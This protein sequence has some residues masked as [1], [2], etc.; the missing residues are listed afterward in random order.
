[1]ESENHHFN[2][3]HS[4]C[5]GKDHQGTLMPF[6]DR[7]LGQKDCQKSQ[8]GF[9]QIIYVSTWIFLLWNNYRFAWSCKK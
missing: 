7:L 1:M 3:Q 5:S 4:D 6:A 2:H 8:G 9:Q